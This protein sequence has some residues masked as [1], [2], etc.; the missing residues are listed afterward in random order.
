MQIV[1][2]VFSTVDCR[3]SDKM[4]EG[5]KR[6][7]CVLWMHRVCDE[8]NGIIMRC[9]WLCGDVVLLPLL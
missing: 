4:K 7:G 6:R 5:E 8:E 2:V 1:N 9:L 3:A